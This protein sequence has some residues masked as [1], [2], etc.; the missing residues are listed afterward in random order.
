MTLFE[1]RQCSNLDCGLRMPVDLDIHR[2]A[3]CPLCGAPLMRGS[4]PFE[5]QVIYHQKNLQ[6]KFLVLLDN[7]RS[8]YNVGAIF[9]T[10][11]GAGVDHLY[12]CGITPNPG[13][14][15]SIAKTALGAEHHISW[16]AHPNALTL[17]ED[18]K[19]KGCQLL[20]LE[21]TPEAEPL[22]RFDV[23]AK[24]EQSLLLIVGNER[25]GVDP[26]L[27][28]LCN[29]VLALPMAGGKTSLN[30]GVAFGI[31]AYWLTYFQNRM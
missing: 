18:L 29:A 24:S 3:F 26:G 13:D 16:S 5:H 6:N 8:A 10:A 9:R 19:E 27:I 7:I 12:L 25:A 15:P 1:M 30:V 17:A 20:A 21:S 4:T 31:A 14:T 28:D 23:R 2:G 11:D 22:D